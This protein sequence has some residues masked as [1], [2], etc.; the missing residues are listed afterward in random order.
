MSYLI[1]MAP[2]LLEI[3]RVLKPTGSLF[4]HCDP[5]ESHGLKLML[6]T[7]FGRPQFRNEI[8]WK[9]TTGRSDGGQYGRVHD[10]IL[11]YAGEGRIWNRP[12]LPHDPEYVKRNYRHQDERGQWQAGDL[13]ASRNNKNGGRQDNPG[14]E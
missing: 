11:F 9:R 1:M 2:R 13:T 6:D 5:T 7:I 8:V 4:L 12:F 3:R 14:G 10:I